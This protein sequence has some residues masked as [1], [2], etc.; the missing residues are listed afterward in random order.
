ML[1]GQ[2]GIFRSL[3]LVNVSL[4]MKDRA[5]LA[6]HARADKGRKEGDGRVER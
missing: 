4:R 2:G 5:F 1:I 6:V 3:V